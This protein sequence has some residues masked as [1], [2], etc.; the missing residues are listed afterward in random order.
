MSSIPVYILFGVLLCPHCPN[1]LLVLIKKATT[2][3][4]QI[5]FQL[6]GRLWDTWLSEADNFT[7]YLVYVCASFLLTVSP[8]AH[9]LENTFSVETKRTNPVFSSPHKWTSQINLSFRFLL[10]FTTVICHRGALLRSV[11]MCVTV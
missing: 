5:P 11:Q 8:T 4:V 10:F 6:V 3:L 7:E 1:E 9:S 2:C